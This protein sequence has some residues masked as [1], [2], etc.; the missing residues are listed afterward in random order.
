MGHSGKMSGHLTQSIAGLE[1]EGR[2]R[3][4][5]CNLRIEIEYQY[6]NKKILRMK[7]TR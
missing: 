5:G 4:K 2:G 6:G 1:G 3:V 7:T